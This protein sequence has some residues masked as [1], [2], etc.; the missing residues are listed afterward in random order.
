MD[1]LHVLLDTGEM[2]S[3]RTPQHNF[4]DETP[5][6][7]RWNPDETPMKSRWN[8]DE[9]PMKPQWNH[10]EIPMKPWWNND[11]TPKFLK[12]CFTSLT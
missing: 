4:F 2:E 12:T 5:M 6:K 11:E 9:I 10:D 3:S 8:P 7:S 1:L